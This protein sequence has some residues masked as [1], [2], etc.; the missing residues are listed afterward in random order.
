M[1]ESVGEGGG[2]G[3]RVKAP[4]P[5]QTHGLLASYSSRDVDYFVAEAVPSSPLRCII[6]SRLRVQP[7][8][9]QH[10]QKNLGPD[11]RAEPALEPASE[12]GPR[13]DPRA[14]PAAEFEPEP[15]PE[16]EVQVEA[17]FVFVLG[18]QLAR[19]QHCWRMRQI[20][21]SW[22]ESSRCRGRRAWRR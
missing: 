10:D 17:E 9:C 20:W 6:S 7:P 13:A 19:L 14:E 1:T 21:T 12:P 4:T 5:T 18:S 16:A 3:M 22:A 11:P 8:P 15:E 2:R